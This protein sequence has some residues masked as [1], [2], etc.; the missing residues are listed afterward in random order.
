MG[1]SAYVAFG[2]GLGGRLLFAPN[3]CDL[4]HNGCVG[5]SGVSNKKIKE[6]MKRIFGVL[7]IALA[8]MVTSCEN[9]NDKVSSD[10]LKGSWVNEEKSCLFTTSSVRFE[11]KGGEFETF[12]YRIIDGN[13][14]HLTKTIDFVGYW[15]VERIVKV[16]KDKIL[17]GCDTFYKVK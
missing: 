9:T 6:S 7:F 2:N 11:K 5:N 17:I 4:N 3:T 10:F 8:F 16:D 14:L 15:N 13:E 12:R 1:I